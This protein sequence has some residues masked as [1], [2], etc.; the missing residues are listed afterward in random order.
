MII[1]SQFKPAWWLNGGNLQTCYPSLF[2]KK[3]LPEGCWKRLELADG[4]FLD[5]FIAE[6]EQYAADYTVDNA[7]II[8]LLHGLEGSIH[9]SYAH[10]LLSQFVK[11]GW[12]GV[13]MHFRGCSGEPNRNPRAYHSGEIEDFTYVLNWLVEQYP[14]RPV[15][16]VGFSLGG[17]VLSVY[18]GKKRQQTRLVGGV[19]V[20]VPLQL[21]ISGARINQ[22]FSRAY[23]KMLLD[24][25]REKIRN[26][27]M[28]LQRLQLSKQD[29]DEISS[30]YHFDDK[31]TA[32]LHDFKSADDYY[33]KSSARQYLINIEKPTLIIHA[34]D[35]PFMTD[36]LIPTAAEL[37]PQVTLELSKSGGHVGF[38]SG[39]N[40]L[41]PEYYLEQ[42]IPQFI[43]QII[44]D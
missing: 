38:V 2:R 9:S 17:S 35:D 42:R 30:F 4:D 43:K 37:S 23:Q 34:K 27:E 3:S 19:A 36:E 21:D 32:P 18:L 26:N 5:L 44:E 13:Q 14:N 22:G 41:Q 29:V 31:I 28:L 20:S 1:E 16:A 6:P 39:K 33:Q 8:V 11:Q 25:L 10:G 40:P 15:A 24:S 12:G 7:P